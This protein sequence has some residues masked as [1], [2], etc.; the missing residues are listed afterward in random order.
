MWCSSST[1]KSLTMESIDNAET[2]DDC[3]R[4]FY[5]TEHLNFKNRVQ[6]W[7]LGSFNFLSPDKF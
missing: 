5:T 2:P 3:I 4:R 6:E 7:S 1:G